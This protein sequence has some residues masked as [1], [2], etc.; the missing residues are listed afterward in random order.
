MKE[1]AINT[2]TGG[3]RADFVDN[4]LSAESYSM[5]MGGR[6]RFNSAKLKGDTSAAK[7]VI[8]GTLAES[9]KTG[10]WT[11]ERGTMYSFSLCEGYTLVGAEEME[12]F[13]IL[14]STNGINSEIGRLYVDSTG[15]NA[16]YDTL[17]NDKNDPNGDKLPF[18]KDNLLSIKTFVESDFIKRQYIVVPNETPLVIN[19]TSFF[20][21]KGELWHSDQ[22][23]NSTNLYPKHLSVHSFCL[24]PDIRVGEVKLSSIIESGDYNL[25]TGT[26]RYSYRLLTKDGYKTPWSIPSPKIFITSDKISEAKHHH[27]YQMGASGLNSKKGIELVIEGVD[28]RFYEIEVAYIS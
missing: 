27:Q 28:T 7:E 15:L 20:N 22:D 17:F 1:S 6:I 23:C 24:Q 10:S 25:L 5:S 8:N 18:S 11:T 4:S 21:N 3:M 16:K 12:D 9:G 19:Y 14:Y 26:Y 2:F 13:C